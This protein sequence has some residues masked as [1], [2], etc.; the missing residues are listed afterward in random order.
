MLKMISLHTINE[1]FKENDCNTLSIKSKMLYIN[2]LTHHFKDLRAT[3]ENQS[4]FS[5]LIKD[6]PHFKIWHDN[7][8]ALE[9]KN[10]VSIDDNSVHFLN[11]WGQHIDRSKLDLE[12]KENNNRYEEY[13]KILHDSQSMLEL[14]MMKHKLSKPRI[15]KL[16]D[17]FIKEQEAFFTLYKS[18]RECVKHFHFWIAH[19]LDK[20]SSD[21][22]K[23][24][25]K[26]LGKQ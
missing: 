4:A 6:I 19:N 1:I 24:Q 5:L 21:K 15:F 16:I 23:S 11:A 3:T 25:S 2:I 13:K 7:F 17:E 12:E 22:V 20:T 18:E 26:I 9:S 8:K 10:L 14:S